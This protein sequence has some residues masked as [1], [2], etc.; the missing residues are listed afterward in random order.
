M[1]RPLAVLTGVGVSHMQRT[2]QTA[3]EERLI[4]V[5]W[6]VLCRP[7][8]GPSSRYSIALGM[9]MPPLAA[10]VAVSHSC[11]SQHC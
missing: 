5:V 9:A 3:L 11:E 2:T 1:V 7:C 4:I 10:A 8:V 6:Q